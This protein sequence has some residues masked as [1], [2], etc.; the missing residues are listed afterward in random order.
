MAATL[1]SGYGWKYPDVVCEPT[2]EEKR[3]LRCDDLDGFPDEGIQRVE[4][5][6]ALPAPG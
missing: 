6:V 5:L 3:P 4:R 1:F 2:S